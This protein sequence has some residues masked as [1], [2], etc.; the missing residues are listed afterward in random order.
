MQPIRPSFSSFEKGDGVGFVLFSM[1]AHELLN[2]FHEFSMYSPTCS[3]LPPHKLC[4]KLASRNLYNTAYITHT[5]M[6]AMKSLVWG[7]SPRFQNLFCDG[8]IKEGSL[9]QKT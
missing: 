2:G 5:S 6:L 7:K 8:P 1:C 4:P 3:S 9:H